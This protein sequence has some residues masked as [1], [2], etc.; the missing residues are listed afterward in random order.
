MARANNS[1]PPGN[2]LQRGAGPGI[3]GLVPEAES[4]KDQGRS[5]P[6]T[7][8]KNP[9]VLCKLRQI[10]EKERHQTDGYGRQGN[11][12]YVQQIIGRQDH[13]KCVD[14]GGGEPVKF[15]YLASHGVQASTCSRS[16][17]ET[18]VLS[19]FSVSWS[20]NRTRAG[21]WFSRGL[22][23]HPRVHAVAILAITWTTRQATGNT[24]EKS[25][26]SLN[27]LG[28]PVD[29]NDDTLH[30]RAGAQEVLVMK[31]LVHC[32]RLLP[33]RSAR[34]HNDQHPA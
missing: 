30:L 22:V 9:N 7:Y 1:A 4:M 31:R 2:G 23:A 28:Q 26:I 34:L 3:R 21:F 27:I 16:L 33:Y 6:Q 19:H 25:L 15:S 8:G 18:Q 10:I 12:C 17:D 14:L 29:Y 24:R 5:S 13:E 20:S 11:E 32:S